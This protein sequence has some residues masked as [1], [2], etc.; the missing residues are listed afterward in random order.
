MEIYCSERVEAPDGLLYIPSVY[1]ERIPT[2]LRTK[3]FLISST[4]KIINGAT[5]ITGHIF[6][7]NGDVVKNQ[8][9]MGTY[10]IAKINN[11]STMIPPLIQGLNR[12]KCVT[13]LWRLV[14]QAFTFPIWL[15]IMV[16]K[17][18]P[19]A[20]MYNMLVAGR[21]SPHTHPPPYN[22]MKN[23]AKDSNASVGPIIP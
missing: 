22:I 9:N 18:A 2:P 3:N 5:M 15:K 8:W 1:A 6:N 19:A 13:A 21:V 10:I 17:K 16:A 11:T 14:L 7:G 12:F 23:T 4:P 20:C